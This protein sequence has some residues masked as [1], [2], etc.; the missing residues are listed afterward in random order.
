MSCDKILNGKMDFADTLLMT[1]NAN[2]VQV[3]YWHSLWTP[4]SKTTHENQLLEPN[5]VP[6]KSWNPQRTSLKTNEFLFCKS[7]ENIV[8]PVHSWILP[9][10]SYRHSLGFVIS[11]LGFLFFHEFRIV[12]TDPKN[13][14]YYVGTS[15]NPL[16][17]LPF[18]SFYNAKCHV[19][20]NKKS[21]N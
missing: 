2:Q 10:D 4:E 12:I 7:D 17:P 20:E 15:L 18:R 13:G 1:Y 19:Q 6:A 11:F 16:L 3:L 5:V 9:L 8:N 14:L 21:K